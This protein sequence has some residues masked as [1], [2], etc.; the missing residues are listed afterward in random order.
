MS[1]T[2][3]IKK[4]LG[5]FKLNVQFEAGDGTM[6][7]LGSSGSGKTMTLK[8][9]AGV[10]RPDEGHIELNGVTLFDSKKGIDLKPQQRQ[11]GYLF[12]NYAL[13]PNMT[14]ERNILCGLNRE[15]DKAKAR[16][17]CRRY[18]ALMGLEGMEE[19]Y[20]H[21]LSGGQQQRAA[22]A[23]ILVGSPRLIMLDEP[24]GALDSHL[25]DRLLMETK[26]ILKDFGGPAIAVTHNRDEA[27]DLCGTI[28]IMEGGSMLAHKGTRELFADPGSI[29]AASITGC[30]NIAPAQKAGEYKLY[31]PDWGIT[32]TTA[33]PVGGRVK[34]VGIRAHSFGDIPEN[35]YAVDV[36]SIAEGPFEDTIRFRYKGQSL[37]S[38]ELWQR[39]PRSL[40]PEALPAGMGV[41]AEDVLALE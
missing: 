41:R 33:K 38:P 2:V 17:I 4:D 30:K 18:M 27:Y 1:L 6:G 28:G 31:V 34:A 23:R 16:E 21:Q 36:L 5:G 26:G 10:E 11:V 13:F 29:A 19:R 39:I 15:K 3:D 14:A 9:I 12:Q 37:E 40:R 25:R 32:L 7:I 35:A 8:C 22:L 24:F 20:P